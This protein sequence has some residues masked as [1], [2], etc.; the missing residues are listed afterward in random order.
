MRRGM[1]LADRQQLREQIGLQLMRRAL[2]Q[3]SATYRSAECREAMQALNMGDSEAAAHLHK[4]CAAE[5]AGGRGC[6]C[7]CHDPAVWARE[8]AS[9]VVSGSAGGI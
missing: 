8:T 9:G 2:R 3:A 4:A 1:S 6:L 5:G 7:E